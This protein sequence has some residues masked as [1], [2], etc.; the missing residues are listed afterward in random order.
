M[1]KVAQVLCFF[2]AFFLFGC[3]ANLD[4]PKEVK[5][6]LPPGYVRY[7]KN[8]LSFQYP[9]SWFIEEKNQSNESGNSWGIFF[10]NDMNL[11]RDGIESQNAVPD[12]LEKGVFGIVTYIEYNEPYEA[13][14]I[15][16]LS[17]YENLFFGDYLDKKEGPKVIKTNGQE[18]LQATYY[19]HL[20]MKISVIVDSEY[21]AIM[22]GTIEL[23]A[24]DTWIETLETMSKSLILHP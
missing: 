4:N 14:P 3:S 12:S 19:A 23:D 18:I 2:L 20:I 24:K 1:I 8:A 10:S 13:T 7:E 11:L 15:E 17:F 5:D 22:I 16:I 21:V 9:D 6:G